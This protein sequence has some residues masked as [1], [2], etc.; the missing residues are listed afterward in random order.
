MFK[1]T[2]SCSFS[3]CFTLFRAS[4]TCSFVMLMESNSF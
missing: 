1:E 3:G 4:I 2:M